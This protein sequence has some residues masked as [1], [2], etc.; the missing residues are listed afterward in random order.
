M[1]KKL[2][3]QSLS[4]ILYRNLVPRGFWLLDIRITSKD[5]GEKCLSLLFIMFISKRKK[6]LGTRL[7]MPLLIWSS[8]SSHWGCSYILRKI[9]EKNVCF[10]NSSFSSETACQ[11]SPQIIP[12]QI[13]FNNFA[14]IFSTCFWSFRIPRTPIFPRSLLSIVF[15]PIHWGI[16]Y[17]SQ[18]YWHNCHNCYKLLQRVEVSKR[19]EVYK[20]KESLVPNF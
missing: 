3:T 16:S 1:S 18:P 19:S 15:E 6:P 4:D 20:Q 7:L 8:K 14:Q 9:L 13:C 11:K 2:T 10:E 5:N 17:S 12:T